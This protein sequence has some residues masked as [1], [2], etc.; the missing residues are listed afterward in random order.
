MAQQMHARQLSEKAARFGAAAFENVT[1]LGLSRIDLLRTRF[2]LSRP[3]LSKPGIRSSVLRVLDSAGLSPTRAARPGAAPQFPAG[4]T[5]ASVTAKN[6]R[7]KIS[8]CRRSIGIWLTLVTPIGLASFL[9]PCGDFSAQLL[10][11]QPPAMWG[12]P[13]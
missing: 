3:T 4:T 9:L 1:R 13:E 8:D 5:W 12:T 6:G 7:F 10:G 2:T 11:T